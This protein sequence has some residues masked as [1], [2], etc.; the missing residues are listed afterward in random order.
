MYP[1][2]KHL[3]PI[4]QIERQ[5]VLRTS[6]WCIYA[7]PAINHLVAVSI[8]PH[9]HGQRDSSFDSDD[10]GFKLPRAA[11]LHASPSSSVL[12]KTYVQLTGVGL[13]R[14]G[15]WD[16]ITR[17]ND[18]QVKLRPD[19]WWKRKRKKRWLRCSHRRQLCGVASFICELIQLFNWFKL[20][21][22]FEHHDTFKGEHLEQK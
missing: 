16:K 21:K 8:F 5:L 7:G 17:R 22:K 1:I 18:F 15:S 19:P 6:G 13:E 3:L 2:C 14:N 20:Q 4:H 11:L 10:F 9:H 12:W